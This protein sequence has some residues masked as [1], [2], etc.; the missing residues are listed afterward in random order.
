MQLASTM[1]TD[2]IVWQCH[3]YLLERRSTVYVVEVEAS[4]QGIQIIYRKWMLNMIRLAKWRNQQTVQ[5]TLWLNN[6]QFASIYHFH[7][8]PVRL[9]GYT[10]DTLQEVNAQHDTF[11]EMTKP[12]NCAKYFMIEQPTICIN[13]SFPF[14][15]SSVILLYNTVRLYWTVL[16]SNITSHWALWYWL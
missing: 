10:T 9:Y 14:C 8:A 6:Q 7:S 16:A 11:G 13:I 15:P 12:T 1:I 5:N 2:F 3:C 4:S